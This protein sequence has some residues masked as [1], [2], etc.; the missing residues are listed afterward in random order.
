[1]VPIDYAEV[2]S[3]LFDDVAK[4][5]ARWKLTDADGNTVLHFAATKIRPISVQW[6]L[7]Q[8]TELLQQRNN[9]GETPLDALLAKA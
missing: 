8:T 5:D 3:R 9:D 4:D 2:L 7:S 6:I 1:L